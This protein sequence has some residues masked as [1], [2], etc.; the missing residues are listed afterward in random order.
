MIPTTLTNF[1]VTSPAKSSAIPKA[2]IMGDGVLAGISTVLLPSALRPWNGSS[3]SYF[4]SGSS[5]CFRSHN[6][7]RLLAT[8]SDA[9]LYAGGGEL[10]DHSRVHA[11]HGSFPAVSPLK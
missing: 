9:K 8:G 3:D 11:S 2:R 7:R 1:V 5:G 10:V 4:Q 6:G